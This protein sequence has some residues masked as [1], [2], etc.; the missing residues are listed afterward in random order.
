ML[1]LEANSL[2]DAQAITEL[3]AKQQKG[4]QKSSPAAHSR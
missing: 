1:G 4:D 2:D 3:D